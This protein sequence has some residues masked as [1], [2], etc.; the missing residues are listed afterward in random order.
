MDSKYRPIGYNYMLY[1][2]GPKF[3]AY[4]N[5]KDAKKELGDR[6]NIA[7]YTAMLY[8]YNRQEIREIYQ[9]FNDNWILCNGRTYFKSLK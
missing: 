9:R 3:G 5:D 1:R 2:S 4:L 7:S 6:Y 8:K